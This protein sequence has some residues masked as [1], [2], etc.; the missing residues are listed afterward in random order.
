MVEHVN[1]YGYVALFSYVLVAQLGVP[2]PSAPLL[3]AAGALA[4]TGRIALLPAIASVVIACLCADSTW[5]LMGRARGRR[6]IGLLCRLS[7][8][9]ASCIHTAEGAMHGYGMPF[10]VVGKFLPGFGLMAAP[11]AGESRTSYRKFLAFDGAGA[12]LWSSTYLFVGRFFGA[13][14][15]RNAYLLQLSAP[16]AVAGVVA[17]VVGVVIGRLLRRRRL[18]RELTR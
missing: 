14:I 8:E 6:V 17:M 2:A 3:I 4:A 9:L 15:E 11:V 7:L 1:R 5:F 12:L 16:I 18:R 10:L 13:L